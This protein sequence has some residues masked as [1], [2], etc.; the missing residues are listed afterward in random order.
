M[1]GTNLSPHFENFSHEFRS[2][3]DITGVFHMKIG[4]FDV[5]RGTKLSP[6]SEDMSHRSKIMIGLDL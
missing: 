6:F 5:Q 4:K 1:P 2:M 3:I